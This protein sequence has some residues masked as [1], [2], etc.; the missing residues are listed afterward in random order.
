MYSLKIISE[1]CL[2]NGHYCSLSVDFE[3]KLSSRLS[4]NTNSSLLPPSPMSDSLNEAIGAMR[5]RDDDPIDL[6]DNPCFSVFEENATSLLGRLLN[7]S[8]QLMDEMIETMP[9]VWR[10]YDRV[11]GIA[12]SNERFQFVFQ[13]EEDLVTVLNDRPWSFNHWTM[14]LDRWVPSPPKD[15]LSTVDVWIRI[16]RIPMNYYKLETMDLL[17]SKVGKVLE[18]AYDPKRSQKD[19]FIRAQVRLNIANPAL[20]EKVLN[21]PSG[22]QA[23]IKFEYEKLRK[24]CF[25]CL[26]LTHEKP[27]CPF[28]RNKS[29][30]IV[31][32]TGAS[33]SGKDT[34]QK[35]Q[36]MVVAPPGPAAPPGFPPLFSQLPEEERV[37]A[38]QYISHSDPT[39]RQARIMRVNQSIADKEKEE[40]RQM[41]RISY[42][43]D[44]G[45]GHV[46]GYESQDKEL[47]DDVRGTTSS[48]KSMPFKLSTGV[49]VSEAEDNT[50][51]SSSSSPVS[52]TVFRIGS[53]IVNHPSGT[54]SEGK[55]ARKRPQR[56][57]R[58]SQLKAREVSGTQAKVDIAPPSSTPVGQEEDEVASAGNPKR[59]AVSS[60]GDHSTKSPKIFSE[61]VA[62]AL[63][64]L[65]P[66]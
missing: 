22:G 9:R 64:P 47:C 33:T 7:P 5:I 41:P 55:K 60:V 61:T 34:A 39:E 17:A 14:L 27:F 20:E 53:S 6:P 66:Q 48:G 58:Q 42:N 19:A 23:L 38:L 3:P 36:E 21:L 16:S 1:Y 10:V 28:L 63:K 26:R 31:K 49:V 4:R 29:R 44:K 11:R 37:A 18:I 51:V 59:K 57:K 50:A 56:W 24:R 45:K 32:E 2:L 54:K 13:R 15:F 35:G 43:L 62:S 12:L 40:V 8:C 65:P 52:P 46:F 25:H 30:P